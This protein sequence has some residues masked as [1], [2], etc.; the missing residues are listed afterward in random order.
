MSGRAASPGDDSDGEASF[1][2]PLFEVIEFTFS[3][4]NTDSEFIIISSGKRFVIRL[5]EDRFL[6]APDLKEQYLFFLKV[7]EAGGY[8]DGQ[9]LEDFEDWA[10]SPF[11]P[12]LRSLSDS[13][14]DAV[15]PRTLHDYLFAETLTYI[16]GVKAGQ[17]SPIQCETT[18]SDRDY[19]GLGIRLPEDLHASFPCYR[20]SEVEIYCDGPDKQQLSK[21]PR[22]VTTPAST[23]PLFLKFLGPGDTRSAK[24]EL[25]IYKK[26]NEMLPGLEAHVP[27]LQGVVRGDDGKVYGLL[28]TC[29]DCR[30]TTLACALR[31]NS[32]VDSRQK[33]KSQI[34]STVD[35]LH[36]AGIIWGDVKADNVLID[37]QDDAWV[38][39]FGGGY[40]E[41]WV[42]KECFETLAGDAQGLANI[43]KHIDG[44]SNDSE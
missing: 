7:A 16:V 34:S 12:I 36:G 5:F 24:R 41:G 13:V 11:L 10:M 6:E 20:P 44:R 31:A 21:R 26:I 33:W 15:A 35:L 3:N 18:Q 2:P 19:L 23:A 9:T 28:L 25:D 22:R 14:S 32:A 30:G 43:I 29:I 39:D 27:R 1:P 42:D 38:I 4:R 8:L 37:G 17:L 40:T